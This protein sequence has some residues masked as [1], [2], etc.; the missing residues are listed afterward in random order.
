LEPYLSQMAPL[1]RPDFS[2]GIM[3]PLPASEP[4]RLERAFPSVPCRA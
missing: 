4:S 3:G 2:A 1:S